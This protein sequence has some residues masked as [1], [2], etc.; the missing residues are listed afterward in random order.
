MIFQ[1]RLALTS[2]ACLALAACG[3]SDTTPETQTQQRTAQ[4]SALQAQLVQRDADR[5]GAGSGFSAGLSTDGNVYAW[6]HNQFGQLGQGNLK[7]SLLPLQVRGLSGVS[8]LALG[9]HHALAMRSDGSLW[10]WG[11]N[12][13][14][15]LGVGSRT[16]GATAP[17]PVVGLS[18][19]RA[20]SAND[21]MSL[22]V[23]HDGSVWTWG[24]NNQQ[25]I[26]APTRVTGLGSARTVAA[27][28]DY[29]LAV[30][31]DGT[32]WGWGKNG[33]GQ[34]GKRPGNFAQPVRIDGVDKVVS[35]AAATMH[36]LALR[37]D[38]SV[39]TWGTNAY[40]QMGVTGY[41]LGPTRINGLPTPV[42]GASGVRQISAGAYNSAVLYS[43][44]S[45]WSWGANHYGQ[46]GDGTNLHRKTPARLNTIGNVVAMAVSD[47]FV[48][49][50]QANGSVQGTG[51]NTTGA[52]GNNT[53]SNTS[54]P[55]PVVGTSGVV[56]LNLGASRA[57]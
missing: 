55:I 11:S 7:D 21:F 45:V 36:V 29:A 31:D 40:N 56:P 49:F 20:L 14:G 26:L 6:G 48:I 51:L 22:A 1:S 17:A 50:L 43:D 16:S 5:I 34:L 13:Y 32:V 38:G 57:R 37:T 2:A 33:Y 47:G 10:G 44:G 8:M 52:L 19:V 28:V 4:R 42:G 3:G 12:H 35:V 46:V 9:G 54:L 53:R 30:A 41:K 23:R 25:N 27:G 15:Q 24:R 39:W 18:S